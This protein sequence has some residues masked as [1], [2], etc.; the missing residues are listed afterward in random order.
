MRIYKKYT[1]PCCDT[2]EALF[3]EGNYDIC[4]NCGWEDD[5]LQRDDPDY[6]GA[7]YNTLHGDITLNQAKALI[8]DGKAIY[9]NYP[10]ESPNYFDIEDD[11]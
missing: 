3:E 2:K 1:C 10:R 8:K 9:K 7:N 5:G 6:L 11:E 4:M